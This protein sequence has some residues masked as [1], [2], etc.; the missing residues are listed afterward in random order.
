M[1]RVLA[2]IPA[3]R[4]STRLPD[5]MLADLGGRALVVHTWSRVMEAGFDRV[6]VATD[7]EE[8]AGVVRAAGG[9]ARLTGVAPN[10]TARVRAALVA[11]DHPADV[12]L[13]VQG[14]EPLVEVATL[15]AVVGALADAAGAAFGVA[16]AAAPLE[17]A[18]AT[19]PE[20]VKVVTGEG[21]RALYFSRSPIPSGGPW[22]VH[23]G[24]YGF[25]PEVLR[26]VVDL[27][28]SRLERAEQLEQLRWLENGEQ[29]RVVDVAPPAPSVDTAADLAHVR[30]ILSSRL[31]SAR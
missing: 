21:G 9:E 11:L 5:K 6:V 18:E 7:D 27:P 25:R 16:T 17:A 8:I 26:R 24:V 20:R 15:R 3:R 4:G 19:R 30:A 10:G 1:T 14:D 13:N 23:V 29:I 31:A 28:E 12:V 22:R 2:V